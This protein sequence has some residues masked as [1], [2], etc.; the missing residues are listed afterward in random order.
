MTH[1]RPYLS[2]RGHILFFRIAVP[3]DLR[4]L[5]GCR[6]FTKTLSTSCPLLAEPHALELAAAAKRIFFAMRQA[7]NDT[8]DKKKME[9]IIRQAIH[10]REITVLKESHEEELWKRE[11][12]HKATVKKARLEAKLEVYETRATSY[13]DTTF[14]KAQPEITLSKVIEYFLNSYPKNKNAA[15]YKKH[16]AVLPMF[17]EITGNMPVQKLRQAHINDFFELVQRLPPRWKNE[18]N[19]L[20]LKPVELAKLE[21]QTLLGPKSFEDTYKA[22]LRPFLISARK[23]WQDQGFP[24][25]LTTDGIEYRGMRKEG[26]SK[27]RSFNEEELVRLFEGQEM[28][29]FANQR[30]SAHYYWLPILGLYTGA[31][32]NEICQLNPQTDI[33]LDPKSKIWHFVITEETDGD[34]RITKST[35]NAVSKRKVPIHS[36]LIELGFLDYLESIKKTK[37]KLVFPEF[38]PTQGRASAEAEKWFRKL[39]ITTGLRD[40]TRGACILGMHAFRHTFLNRAFNLGIDV[41]T[42]TGHA[43]DTTAV[44]RG[45]TGELSLV[46]KSSLMEKIHFSLNFPHISC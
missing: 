22:C 10:M 26:E 39:L 32:V 3:H 45:Y 42:L 41:T 12:A 24:T 1:N 25:T 46:N 18:C 29:D 35:K 36:K 5:I 19:K 2:R 30:N 8:V 16:T 38:K 15:M 17:L 9:K 20:K 43:G 44:V 11:L 40:E 4:N 23:D 13:P 28:K 14:T 7:M 37:V 31:R 27:Q 33:L 34:H 21:H 6:E